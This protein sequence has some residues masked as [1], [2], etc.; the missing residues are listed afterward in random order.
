M[1][2]GDREGGA[3]CWEHLSPEQIRAR[4][5]AIVRRIEETAAKDREESGS[6]RKGARFLCGL[7]PVR[8]NGP[9]E[10]SPGL[11]PEADAL[12]G[13]MTKQCGL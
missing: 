13:E 5:E 9:G 4:V 6:A 12:G 2:E 11:R 1:A 3:A 8:P 7:L 10:R